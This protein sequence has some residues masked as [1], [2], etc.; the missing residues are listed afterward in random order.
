MFES[1]W[2]IKQFKVNLT[3]RKPRKKK[4]QILKKN[5][6]KRMDLKSNMKNPVMMK[7]KKTLWQTKNCN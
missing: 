5:N 7:S 4:S 2:I 6:K 1:I 3:K